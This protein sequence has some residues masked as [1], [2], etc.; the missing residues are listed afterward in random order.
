M[1]VSIVKFIVTC[2]AF[3]TVVAG[4]ASAGPVSERGGMCGGIAGFQCAPGL[5]CDFRPS[6]QCGAADRTG[7]C[8]KRPEMCA[9]IFKPVCGC[10]GKTYSNDC[11]RRLAGV[12]KVRN[13]ACQ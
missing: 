6:A 2:L 11:M 10:D 13:R 9:Q 5:F 8:R 12:G 3:V 7:V 4:A 1:K